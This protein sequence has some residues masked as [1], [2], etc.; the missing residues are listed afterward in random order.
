MI[1]RTIESNRRA[2]SAYYHDYGERRPRRRRAR[3]AD[4]RCPEF[5]LASR[6]SDL[7]HFVGDLCLFF[8]FFFLLLFSAGHIAHRS[9]RNIYTRGDLVRR[10]AAEQYG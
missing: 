5:R 7:L 4:T 1:G 6:S 9:G 10:F 8:F 3:A 2:L